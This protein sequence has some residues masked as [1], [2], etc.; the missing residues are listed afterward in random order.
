MSGYFGR[1]RTEILPYLPDPCRRL[2]DL[3]CGE[4]A[5]LEAVR[6][7][8]ELDWAGGAELDE[9]AAAV[10]HGRFDRVWIGDVAGAPLERE[11][12][13]GSLDLVLCLDILEHLPDPWALVRR[14]SPLLRPGGRLVVSVPNVRHWK[15]LWRL[16]VLGDFRYRAA[17]LLDA[18]H[19]RFFTAE[20]AREL[21]GCGGLGVVAC[22]NATRYGPWDVRRWLQA[23]SF[24]RLDAVLAKQL[25]V[26][27]EGPAPA[28]AQAA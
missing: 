5:T 17:G 16:A 11:V 12:A 22:H 14:V 25:I 10:A 2:L 21:A 19:L 7:V 6:G 13:P 18:T 4:G 26:V 1:A 8:R 3:G 15:F 20:T 9:A 28:G 27:A 23:A 24:G